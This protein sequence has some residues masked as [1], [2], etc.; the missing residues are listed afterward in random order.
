MSEGGRWRMPDESQGSG[1]GLIRVAVLFFLI[2]VL[3]T[4][5]MA[6]SADSEPGPTCQKLLFDDLTE[7]QFAFVSDWL[8]RM[9]YYWQSAGGSAILVEERLAGYIRSHMT[10]GGVWPGMIRS[11]ELFAFE[12]PDESRQ[13]EFERRRRR[14][15]NELEQTLI[16]LSFVEHA[17]VRLALPLPDCRCDRTPA[18]TRVTVVLT[19][20]S[21]RLR[22]S[23]RQMQSV[24]RL[25]LAA[26][27]G[28]TPEMIT[29]MD[30]D[31]R[32]LLPAAC[33]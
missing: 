20:A 23:C 9:G 3:G 7:E 28:L 2:V 22:S 16:S 1:F 15:E 12:D 25:T 19:P 32:E 24:R 17:R 6:S 29:V 21:D 27:R 5:L 4:F 8:S 33:P 30:T 11:Y 13:R 18:A 14:V 10:Q 31:G 26:V